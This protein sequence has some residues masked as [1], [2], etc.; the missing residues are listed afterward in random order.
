MD[1]LAEVVQINWNWL[2]S[3]HLIFFHFQNILN[4]LDKIFKMDPSFKKWKLNLIVEWPLIALTKRLDAL[5]T[6]QKP[7]APINETFWKTKQNWLP[8]GVEK[9]DH[10]KVVHGFFQKG[11]LK[12]GRFLLNRAI[13]QLAIL[14][15]HVFLLYIACMLSHLEGIFGI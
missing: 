6:T 8:K 12:I 3:L 2:K 15:V 1:N 14:T 7:P 13:D 11:S 5:N 9:R 4:H 10:L